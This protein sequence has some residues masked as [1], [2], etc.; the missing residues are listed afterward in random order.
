MLKNT[1][2]SYRI[3]LIIELL[4]SIPCLIRNISEFVTKTG[5]LGKLSSFLYV[6]SIII[7]FY[8]IIA[9]YTK[10]QALSYKLFILLRATALFFQL[11]FFAS[12]NNTGILLTSALEFGL[13]IAL[14]VGKDLGKN[15]SYNICFAIIL[16]C[17]VKTIFFISEL[18][19]SNINLVVSIVTSFASALIPSWVTF[20]KYT[21][22]ESRGAK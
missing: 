8:Y 18:G 21:D 6:V 3:I 5:V 4:L 22:K 9:G 13:L 2:P 14:Y 7:A 10:E 16:A 15:I 12:L 1:K 20:A 11:S 17:I 19:I